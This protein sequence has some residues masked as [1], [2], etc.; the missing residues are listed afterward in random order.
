VVHRRELFVGVTILIIASLAFLFGW[1]NIFSVREVNVTG[2]PDSAI[3]SQVLH[4]AD[5]QVGEKLARIEPRNI[6]NKIAL[7][8][9][10]WIENIKISRNWISRKV[11]IN[12]KARVPVAIAGSKYVDAGGTLFTSP[13]PVTGDLINISALTQAN[14]VAAVSFYLALPDELRKNLTKVA[15]TSQNN[16]QI[17]LKDGLRIIWGANSDTALKV[18][19]YKALLPLPENSKIKLMDLSDPTKPSVK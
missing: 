16:F 3:T 5:I 18:K 8:G 19:I 10:D 12:I 9:I 15:A 1:T 13:I 6:A 7:A 11:N 17:V 2:S 14:R 4:I